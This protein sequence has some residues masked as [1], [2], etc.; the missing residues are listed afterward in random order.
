MSVLSLVAYLLLDEPKH[1]H[2]VAGDGSPALAEGLYFAILI[3]LNGRLGLPYHEATEASLEALCLFAPESLIFFI[4]HLCRALIHDFPK[5]S[6]GE[7]L[8]GVN[9]AFFL[10]IVL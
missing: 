1:R 4:R 7:D 3:E 5:A 6:Y 10:A 2:H 9:V 8:G